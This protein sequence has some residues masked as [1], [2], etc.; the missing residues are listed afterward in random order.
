MATAPSRPKETATANYLVYSAH[1]VAAA[2]H[3][4]FTSDHSYMTRL[5]LAARESSRIANCA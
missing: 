5:G 3:G 2:L 4:K 1:R